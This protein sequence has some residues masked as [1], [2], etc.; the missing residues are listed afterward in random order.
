MTTLR[1]TAILIDDLLNKNY[2]Y[3]LASRF[4]S[5]PIEHHLNKYRQMSGG[6]FIVSLRFERGKQ[7]KG[8]LVIEFHYQSRSN[9]LGS[10]YLRQK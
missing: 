5:D 7:L 1:C 8:D 10:K 2:D 6:R 9:F 4:Q 3:I